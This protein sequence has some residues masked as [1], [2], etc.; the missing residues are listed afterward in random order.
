MSFVTQ[1]TQYEYVRRVKFRVCIG[2]TSL[3]SA[4][5]VFMRKSHIDT[6]HDVQYV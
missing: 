4:C 3:R 1:I 2:L 5:V 6:L